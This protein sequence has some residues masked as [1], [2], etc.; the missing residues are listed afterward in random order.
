MASLCFR[1]IR[2]EQWETWLTEHRQ[3]LSDIQAVGNTATVDALLADIDAATPA[4]ACGSL[5]WKNSRRW[6]EVLVELNGGARGR[7][8][9]P[10]CTPN[11]RRDR[12]PRRQRR[13][14][15][16]SF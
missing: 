4:P 10:H 12:Y 5:V 2:A 14:E 6:Q 16:C 11:P 3:A 9:G 1:T 13:A 15:Q 8:G 7:R